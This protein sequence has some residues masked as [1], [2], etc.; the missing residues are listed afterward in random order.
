MRTSQF[1]RT[2]CANHDGWFHLKGQE[3][4]CRFLEG[5]RCQVYEARPA[6]CR[7]WPFWPENMNAKAWD[8]EV[9]RF[10]PG[11]GRGRKYSAEEIQGL[12]AQDPLDDRAES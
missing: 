2:Y 8:R 11:V 5:K 4:A 1:T 10:C 9:V 3:T 6:Q 12:L 7:T